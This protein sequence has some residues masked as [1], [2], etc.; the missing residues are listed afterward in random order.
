MKSK[1]LNETIWVVDKIH[2]EI[3]FKVRHLMI[4]FVKGTFQTFNS[5]ITT[6]GTDFTTAQIQLSIDSDSITTGDRERDEHLTGPDFLDVTNHSQINF[7][8]TK[9]GRSRVNGNHIVQGELSILGK[10]KPISL[11]VHFGGILLDPWGN[12]KAG[13]HVNGIINRNDWGL[14]WNT[15][16]K[17]GGFLIGETVAISCEF[18]LINATKRA[19]AREK[20][21][22]VKQH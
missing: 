12:E 7:I 22:L 11:T 16:L 2:S 15:P 8:S 5:I 20:E 4:A 19:R 3:G 10:T 13:F 17:T 18:E 14:K 6:R 9:A 21:Y 1:A